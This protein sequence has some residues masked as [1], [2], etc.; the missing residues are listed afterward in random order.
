MEWH[1]WVWSDGWERVCSAPTIG[2]C[3]REL[4]R[5]GEE[6]G[7][8]TWFQV[9]TGGCPPTFKR[10]AENSRCPW[11]SAFLNPPHVIRRPSAGLAEVQC[12]CG[13]THFCREDEPGVVILLRVADLANWAAEQVMQQPDDVLPEVQ[14]PLDGRDFFKPQS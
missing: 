12:G 6:R 14:L 13:K 11:C 7:V 4:G 9:L 8:P 5:I 1:G 3:S 2:E 10:Q